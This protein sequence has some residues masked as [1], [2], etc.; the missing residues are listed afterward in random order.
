M[1][2]GVGSA[3]FVHRTVAPVVCPTCEGVD[4]SRRCPSCRGRGWVEVSRSRDPYSIDHVKAAGTDQGKFGHVPDRDSEIDRLVE[5]TAVPV[6][7]ELDVV[8]AAN[9]HPFGWEEARRVMYARF[10]YAALDRCLERLAGMAVSAYSERGLA[11]LDQW[12]PVPLRAPAQVGVVVVNV[13]ARGRGADRRALEQRDRAVL[14]LR[15]EGLG[16]DEIARRVGLSVRQLRRIVNGSE[17]AE[18][19]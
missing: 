16:Y 13:A 18:N 15:Q 11:L 7:T 19:P 1:R 8:A 9:E 3:G 4:D 12:L 5:Q 2:R 14:E 17:P 6:A 10:D